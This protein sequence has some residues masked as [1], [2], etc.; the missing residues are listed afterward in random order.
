MVEINCKRDRYKVVELS[1]RLTTS[2][3]G[4]SQLEATLGRVEA[5]NASVDFY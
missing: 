4:L 5:I 2:K 1:V 3:S